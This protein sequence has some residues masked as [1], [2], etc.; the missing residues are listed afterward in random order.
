MCTEAL[1]EDVV[2]C[3]SLMF[4]GLPLQISRKQSRCCVCI[5]FMHVIMLKIMI[6]PFYASVMVSGGLGLWI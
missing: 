5:L 1:P 2:C 6:V 3:F 4:S